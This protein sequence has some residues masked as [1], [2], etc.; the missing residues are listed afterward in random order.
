MSDSTTRG[1]QRRLEDIAAILNPARTAR[2][3]MAGK[4]QFRGFKVQDSHGAWRSI[5]GLRPAIRDIFH[6]DYGDS[7]DLRG[8]GKKRARGQCVLPTP[9][10]TRK[11]RRSDRKCFGVMQKH[12]KRAH[13]DTEKLVNHCIVNRKRPDVLLRELISNRPMLETF[14]ACAVDVLSEIVARHWHPVAAELPIF[15]ERARVA[16]RA[17]LV[18]FDET[19]RKIVAVELTFG[20]ESICYEGLPGAPPLKSPLQCVPN[21]AIQRKLI[22][23]FMAAEILRICHRPPSGVVC[24]VVLRVCPNRGQVILYGR[25]KWWSRP[26]IREAVYSAFV[27]RDGEVH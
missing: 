27:R 7:E 13:A 23:A 1:R 8:A 21:T 3:K 24:P 6:P 14:D 11:M 17:D 18:V 19:E 20:W 16:T 2:I 22:Q 5:T 9:R 26:E 10:A 12:G 15:D 25:A 4:G